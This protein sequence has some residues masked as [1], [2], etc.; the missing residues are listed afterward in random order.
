MTDR[1]VTVPDSLELPAAVKVG[2]DRLHDST[3]AGRALLTGADAAA[4]RSSLGLGTAATASAG[5]YATAAQ[6]AKADASDVH[7]I[8][9]TGNLALT[10]PEGHPAGQ[11]Y[12]CAITQTTGGH[13]VT[14]GG[15]VVTVDTAA[16]AVTRV[17]LWPDG[18]G[19]RVAQAPQRAHIVDVR[20][21]GAKGDNATDNTAA[22]VAAL[23]AAGTRPVYFPSGKYIH[24]GFA[25]GP[26]SHLVG[27][28]PLVS[29]LRNVTAGA[30]SITI[31]GGHGS[32]SNLGVWG[33]G[34]AQ[35]GADATTGHGIVFAGT[36]TAA[37]W[38]LNRVHVSYH[39]GDGIRGGYV[40]HNN[41]LHFTSV[42][43]RRNKLHGINLVA[44]KGANSQ[45]NGVSMNGGDVGENGKSG[46]ELWGNSISVLNTSI[47]ANYEYGVELNGGVLDGTNS[48]SAQRVAIEQCHFEVNRLGMLH[49]RVGANSANTYNK[50]FGL[51]VI[52]N[53]TFPG[54]GNGLDPGVTHMATFTTA[55]QTMLSHHPI[56]QLR[57]ERNMFSSVDA[58]AILN[59]GNL[60][61][62][63]NYIDDIA[64]TKFT[65]LAWARR[66][67]CGS[68]RTIVLNNYLTGR[69]ASVTF[70]DITTGKSSNI[71]SPQ[72]IYYPLDLNGASS[73]AG[74][75][76]PIET[77]N[78]NT[79]VQVY[80]YGRAKGSS[81][82]Y[83]AAQII[84][85]TNIS[86][87]VIAGLADNA[88]NPLAGFED[89][90]A[91]VIVTPGTGGTYCYIY[92][93]YLTTA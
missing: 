88:N 23:A 38:D 11:V 86:G 77:D 22:I 90:Y 6:G 91:R 69:A 79:Q 89:C 17:D 73:I 5:D 87:G 30:D 62:G 85:A 92:N 2:V 78:T 28:G 49:V 67:S 15:N 29:I 40:A 83:T 64:P 1:F 75:G 74:I 32:I 33:D 56:V 8:T 81:A 20:D 18:S 61:D 65:G 9:L 12:R 53:Y 55:G 51:S 48:Y 57:W 71:T 42:D 68:R 63:T 35:W 36:G 84:T 66:T 44:Y 70:A 80:L 41:D 24:T 60:L 26:N 72:S 76:V 10:I 47:Q 50:V 21:Y 16:N 45:I 59:G 93:P 25:I 3:V 82:A 39:G 4:Q 54:V 31:T 14:Y 37:V 52:G 34:T 46:L 27:D 58:I 43:V 19:W 7:Q 13:T